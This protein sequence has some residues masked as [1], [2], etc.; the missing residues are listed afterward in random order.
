M[1]LLIFESLGAQEL[2][3]VGIVAL[4]VFGPRKLPMMARKAGEM[5]REFKSVSNDFKSTWE[6]EINFEETTSQKQIENESE[7]NS[8]KFFGE[9]NTFGDELPVIDSHNKVENSIMPEIREVS[10][11][12]FKKLVENQ[13]ELETKPIDNTKSEKSEWF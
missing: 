10:S 12:D 8:D 13:K 9:D 11:E 1:Y 5:M 3:L 4:I 6:K 7:N 2:I